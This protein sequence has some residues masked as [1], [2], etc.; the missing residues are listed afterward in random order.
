M[1]YSAGDGAFHEVGYLLGAVLQVYVQALFGD[2]DAAV[3]EPLV[4]VKVVHLQRRLREGLPLD[5]L[6]LAAP[7]A[8]GVNQCALYCGFVGSKKLARSANHE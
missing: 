6:G 4:E 8:Q 7:I 2:V 5:P 1:D 3:R